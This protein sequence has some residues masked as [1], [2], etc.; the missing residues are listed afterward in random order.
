MINNL[1]RGV[2]IYVAVI[3]AVRLMG[4]R[5]IGELQP[6]ELV[7]TILLSEV[8]ALPLESD[9]VPLIICLSLI[10]LLAAFEVLSSELSVKFPAFRKF[11]QGNSVIVIKNGKLIPKHIKQLRYSVDDLTEALRLKDVFDIQ[12]VDFAY[13]ETNGAVSIKLKKDCRPPTNSDKNTQDGVLPCLVISDGKILQ[14]E[15]DLCNMTKE[16]LNK[17]LKK[18]G[19]SKND[20][21]LMTADCTGKYYIVRK[22]VKQ[23]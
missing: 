22:Q 17:I 14:R 5:Q 7:I 11:I 6:S 1:V 23:D 8:A 21:L 4:K 3:A 15:F 10:F 18:E 12:D 9:S 20:V 2:I 19:I 16:K 13:V